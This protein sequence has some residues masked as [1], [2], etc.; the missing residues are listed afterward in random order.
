MTCP[1]P[2]STITQRSG[3]SSEA[4]CST[5]ATTRAAVET[6]TSQ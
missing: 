3:R 4:G 2:A 5:S 6:A 1:V